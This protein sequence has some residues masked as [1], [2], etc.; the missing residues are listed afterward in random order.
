LTHSQQFELSALDYPDIPYQNGSDAMPKFMRA[1]IIL[2][3]L[4]AFST[5]PRAA[6]APSA[7][8]AL[9][10]LNKDMTGVYRLAS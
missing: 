3:F 8:Q 6:S 1:T 10:M 7:S 9:Q 2:A 5:L 4:I